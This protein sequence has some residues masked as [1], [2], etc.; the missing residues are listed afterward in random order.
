MPG[1]PVTTTTAHTGDI[2][3]YVAALGTVTPVNTVSVTS[4]VQG[5][6]ME[7]HY[8]EGQL[9][10]KG[11]PLL[12]IDPRPFQ[13]QLTQVQGQLAHDQALLNEARIDLDRYQ[14]A[15]SKNAIAKQQVDDQQQVV[16]Q[17]SEGTVAMKNDQGQI[18]T[19]EVNLQYCNIKSPIDGRVGLR[20]VDPGNVVQANGTNPALVVV[21]QLQPITVIFSVAEDYLPQI[22]R[23][24]KKGQRLTV[25]AFDRTQQT[26]IANGYLLT[27]D[28]QIDTTT[29]TVKLR[30]VFPNTAES[31][32]PSQFV[33]ARLLIETEKNV[34]LVPTAA[35]QRNAQSAFV[36]VIG[37]D[38][39]ASV[40]NI[41][42][43]TTDGAI[44]A[45]QGVK[46]AETVV[47]SEKLRQVTGRREGGRSPAQYTGWVGSRQRQR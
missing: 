25:D 24:L 44:A 41:T 16:F 33:N 13:A 38:Q 2:G 19:I 3:E 11:D 6:I 21:T 22:Q 17:D 27:L 5:E 7:V 23:Q 31:L 26:K 29:G 15:F 1:V 47:T 10:K 18:Q 35:V 30:A 8:T 14:A 4:R 40:R 42:E 37:A 28:N 39:K 20:L 12:L 45:V 32:F 46:S 36:Y 43:G 9:V 34:V